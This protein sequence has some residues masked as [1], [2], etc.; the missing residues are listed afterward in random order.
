MDTPQELSKGQAES[1]PAWLN[2][3][4]KGND[5]IQFTIEGK[6]Y[7]MFKNNRKEEGSKQPDY[8]I[9]VSD[10]ADTGGRPTNW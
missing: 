9:L 2:T 1:I 5:Y 3:S 7:R 6:K 4:K 8:N 10:S